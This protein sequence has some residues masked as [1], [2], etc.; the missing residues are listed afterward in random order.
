MEK[1]PYTR[2]EVKRSWW[3]APLRG[4]S[5]LAFKFWWAFLLFFT[6]SVAA[7]YWWCFL[8]YCKST[9]ACCDVETYHIK[10]KSAEQKLAECCDCTIQVPNAEEIIVDDEIEEIE[11]LRREYGGCV[12]DVTVTLRW[13]TKDDLDLHI[14]EPNGDSINFRT[15]V[16]PKRSHYGGTLD[17]DKNAL[18][19]EENPIENICYPNTPPPGKFT[20]QVHFFASKS[21]ERA[22]PYEVLVQVGE[23]IKV[24]SGVHQNEKEKH[25]ICDFNI[26]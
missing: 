13:F 20:I 15:Y 6:L 17:V 4:I 19:P 3:Y 18:T 26:R 22:I 9:T 14:I 5:Y 23:E 2:R 25:R 7:W 24:Y 16:Y 1:V 8:P 21:S 12:G 11:D 10:I